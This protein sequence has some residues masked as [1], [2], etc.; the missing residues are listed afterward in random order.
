MRSDSLGTQFALGRI[1]GRDIEKVAISGSVDLHQ[2]QVRIEAHL[3]SHA[4]LDIEGRHGPEEAR[5]QPLSAAPS[6]QGLGGRAVEARGPVPVVHFDEDGT[7][8]RG[9]APAQRGVNT[10]H[11]AAT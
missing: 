2:P 7:G 4:L 9:P 11:R 8:L 5:E 1:L 3:A 6:D 10:F